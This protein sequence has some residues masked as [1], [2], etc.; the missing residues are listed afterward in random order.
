[1]CSLHSTQHN[2][3]D[4]DN[5]KVDKNMQI[6]SLALFSIA[7]CRSA[8]AYPTDGLKQLAARDC[9]AEIATFNL[10][11]R[12]RRGDF[13]RRSIYPTMKNLTCI[14]APEASTDNYIANPPLRQDVTQGQTQVFLIGCV[15]SFTDGLCI[16]FSGFALTMDIGVLDVTTCQ[17]LPNA[18]VEIWSPNA[19]GNYGTFLRGALT[20]ASNGIAE[21]QTIFP[22]YT[23]EGAN[24]INLLVHTSSS[25]TSSVT[26]AGRVFFTDK[27]TTIVAMQPPYNTNTHERITNLDDPVYA[28]AGKTG[29][30]PVIDVASIHDDWPEG[31]V[32]YITVGV[33]PK[34][35]H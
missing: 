25:A 2:L 19:L 34:A 31:M 5:S 23:S 9:S 29:F 3:L 20:T 22:G 30:Y 27:W 28:A 14:L 15:N 8:L 21:F 4:T 32:G 17:P 18:M 33:N 26:H 16:S 11:R 24:H 12:E 10:A 13:S 1:M 7:I 6:I 35:T